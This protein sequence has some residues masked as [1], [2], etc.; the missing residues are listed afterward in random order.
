MFG[1]F[2]P[3]LLHWSWILQGLQLTVEITLFGVFLGLA[4]AIVL[5]IGDIYGNKV[6]K[7]IIAVYVEAV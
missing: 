7:G 2:E 4:L 5:A 1:Q 3:V 6:V